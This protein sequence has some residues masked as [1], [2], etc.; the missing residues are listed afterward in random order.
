MGSRHDAEKVSPNIAAARLG[1][2]P[3]AVR[4]YC[5]AFPHVAQRIAYR[6]CPT[7]WSYAIDLA[8]LAVVV[9]AHPR[10]KWPQPPAECATHSEAVEHAAR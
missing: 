10:K 3:W 1:I 6:S 8:A 5:Q 2:T 7:G 9:E 4:K